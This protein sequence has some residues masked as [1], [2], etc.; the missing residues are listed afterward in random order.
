VVAAGCSLRPRI[1][2][3]AVLIA[4][5]RHGNTPAP[6]PGDSAAPTLG[7]AAPG[8]FADLAPGDTAGVIAMMRQVMRSVDA[9]LGDM[10]QRDTALAPGDDST[11]H[12]LT[13]WLQDGVPRKLVV[14]DSAGHGQNN[15]E[16][17]VWFMGGEVAVL[18]QVTDGY[19]FDGD[20]IVL[21]TDEALQPRIDATRE[22]LMAKQAALI[23]TVWGWLRTLH[24]ALP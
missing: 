17:E 4:G 8:Q 13:V 23:E 1:A 5:C 9:G 6:A 15:T 24:I 21:W 10:V 19:A 22:A 7:T 12:H 18:M 14:V 2:L 3:L 16:T 20:R 11:S